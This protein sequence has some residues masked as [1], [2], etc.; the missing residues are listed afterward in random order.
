MRILTAGDSFTYGEELKDLSSAWPHL[1]AKKLNRAVVNLGEPAA[2]NDK[3]IRKVLEYILT[4]Q[5]RFDLVVIAWT[6]L[7]RSEFADDVG[8]YDIWPGYAGNLFQ[9]DNAIWRNQLLDYINQYHNSQAY[10]K[11]FLQQVVLLQ[12]FLESKKI[13]YVM[14]NTIQNEYY[15]Q[16]PVS[17]L[18]EYF[19]NI[20]KQKF[21]GFNDG[22]MVEWA[23][24]CEKGP[25]GHFLEE[26][27]RIVADKIYEHLRYIGWLA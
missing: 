16:I 1:L 14:L 5:E 20:D 6:S 26:G 4:V 25:N 7:G 27:H 3:I 10:Y 8:Y 15:K 21:L 13:K 18:D 23:Y 2:S 11:K 19:D 22:G 17:S 9:K 12:S 24:G